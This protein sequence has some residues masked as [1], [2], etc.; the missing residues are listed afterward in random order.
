MQY[1]K[2]VHIFVGEFSYA[3]NWHSPR[4]RAQLINNADHIVVTYPAFSMLYS[5]YVDVHVLPIDLIS[6]CAWP[7]TIG[8]HDPQRGD[9]TPEFLKEYCRKIFP[10]ALIHTPERINA[11]ENNPPGIF[12]HLIPNEN[13]KSDILNL[14]SS[15]SSHDTICI[16]PKLRT[17]GGSSGQNWQKQ[18]WIDLC[19]DL[20]RRNYNIVSINIV[21]NESHGGSYQLDIDSNKFKV[22]NIEKN[23]EYALD[24]QAWLLKQTKCSIYGSTGAANFPFWVNTPTIAIMKTNCGKRLF[25]DWQKQLTNNHKNNDIILIDDLSTVRY[26]DIAERIILHLDKLSN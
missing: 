24:R 14:L 25:F 19:N 10:D 6:K 23:D 4:L 20:I 1:K 8:L 12:R 9:I 21:D 7:A 13:I 2:H 3:M 5:N 26:H 11:L 17:K 16:M 15:W 18:D 22:L